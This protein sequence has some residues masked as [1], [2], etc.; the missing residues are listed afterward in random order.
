MFRILKSKRRRFKELAWPHVKFLYN[1]ALGY[2]GGRF[3][4]EDMV[5]ETLFIAFREFD[6]L[7]DER[8]CKSWLFAILRNVHLK[9]VRN[10]CSKR[11]FEWNERG[12]YL[13]HL[14]ELGGN[15]DA[16]S[17]LTERIEE[18]E[19]RRQ[20]GGLPEKYKSPLLLHYME[21]LGVREIAEY[22]D[23]PQG[24][25]MSR[26]SRAREHLKREMLRRGAGETS[27]KNV[28][29]FSKKRGAGK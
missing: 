13:D 1:M 5:Q 9:E 3:D 29:A 14:E 12:N 16:E 25:V 6:K 23:M 7:R 28:L 8:K 17:L 11:Q 18:E 21:G 27:R 22:L 10:I 20:V 2:A 15:R 4:A 26:L 19:L 24:T